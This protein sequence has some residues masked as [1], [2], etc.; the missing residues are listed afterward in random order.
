MVVS[1]LRRAL[2]ITNAQRVVRKA[3][4]ANGV[5]PI[6]IDGEQFKAFKLDRV[7]SIKGC[8][9]GVEC[10]MSRYIGNFYICV[11]VEFRQFMFGFA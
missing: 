8:R 3:F 5:V 2:R 9:S 6:K 11:D 7:V 10:G 4:Q 1:T